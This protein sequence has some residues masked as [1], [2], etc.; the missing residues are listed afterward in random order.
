MAS[1]LIFPSASTCT[2]RALDV[3][4]FLPISIGNWAT[5]ISGKAPPSPKSYRKHV[6][7]NLDTGLSD[8]KPPLWGLL[9]GEESVLMESRQRT[10]VEATQGQQSL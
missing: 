7:Q 10:G 8:V 6:Q 2:A 5:W 3:F 4:F 1:Y 9:S